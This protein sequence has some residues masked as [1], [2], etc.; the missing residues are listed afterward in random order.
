MNL[1][2][3]NLKHTLIDLLLFRSSAEKV[4]AKSQLYFLSSQEAFEAF[5]ELLGVGKFLSKSPKAK[6]TPEEYL[7]KSSIEKVSAKFQ[8]Y[9][10]SE[11]PLCCY[12]G[13]RLM[14]CVKCKNN[15][16]YMYYNFV[17]T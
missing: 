3:F 17:K 9:I 13:C 12:I 5:Q 4:S 7:V 1:C 10:G 6:L 8:Q 11:C 14:D 16:E 15:F 2:Q